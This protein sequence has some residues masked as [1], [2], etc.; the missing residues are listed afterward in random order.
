MQFRECFVNTGT[1]DIAK[2]PGDG[3]FMSDG[4]FI[5]RGR[6]TTYRMGSI[7]I[8]ENEDRKEITSIRS[9]VHDRNDYNYNWKLN[10]WGKTHPTED[11]CMTADIPEKDPIG[12]MT[13]YLLRNQTTND[14]TITAV[15]FYTK[16]GGIYNFGWESKNAEK[17]HKATSKSMIGFDGHINPDTGKLYNIGMVE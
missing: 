1:L 3:H 14:T 6:E 4:H 7:R 8:C 11:K 15:S 17:W 2:D 10:I 16:R 12:S 9:V 13:F 5:A